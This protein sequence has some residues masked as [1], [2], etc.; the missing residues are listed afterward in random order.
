MNPIQDI[1]LFRAYR[2]LLKEVKPDVV[3]TYTIKPNVYGG[4]ACRMG[5]VPYIA[6]ITGL[7]SALENGGLVQKIALTLYKIG[8]KKASCV[9]LQNQFNLSF[10]EEHNITKAPK[11]LISGSGVNLTRFQV[12]SLPKS[13]GK[14]SGC[15]IPH[16]RVL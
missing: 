11:R 15:Q 6:N 10:F 7:G 5:N 14:I 9:F 16:I 8:L 13:T 2:K 1:G 12:K 3:L 4:L